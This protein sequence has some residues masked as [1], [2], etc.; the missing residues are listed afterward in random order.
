MMLGE[1]VTE[2]LRHGQFLQKPGPHDVPSETLTSSLD[3]ADTYGGVP[4]EF[5]FLLAFLYCGFRGWII[6]YPD[7]HYALTAE[8]I[9]ERDRRAAV[10]H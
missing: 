10:V 6:Q 8:G 3:L 4:T 7:C 2:T 5:V 9:E 1:A